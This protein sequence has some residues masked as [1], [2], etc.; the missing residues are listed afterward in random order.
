VK[1]FVFGVLALAAGL[2]GC[3][4]LGYTDRVLWRVPS[5]DGRVVA[6]CQE[7]PVF[8]GPDFDIRL[9]Q[10]NGVLRQPLYRIGDGDPCTEVAWAPDGRTLA[11]L[12]GHVARIR[13]VDVE[14]ALKSSRVPAP[15]R[16]VDLS[17]ERDLRLGR[18]L[19]FVGPLDVEVTTCSY[20]LEETQ[21]SGR[22][23]CITQEIQQRLR[24]PTIGMTD[25]R[26][27]STP[28]RPWRS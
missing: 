25:R 21:R 26:S 12:S 22:M 5:P 23:S 27:S 19:R 14:G 28:S 17:A 18:N 2:S 16:Q 11:V 8:D 9:E 15:L 10:P 20:R 7:I 1:L 4:Q 13:F 24:V 6:V 3:R